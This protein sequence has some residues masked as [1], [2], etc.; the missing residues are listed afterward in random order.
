MTPL[1]TS[2]LHFIADHIKANGSSP[3]FQAIADALEIKSKA[4][5]SRLV[6]ILV[7][8]GMVSRIARHSCN[9][10]ITKAG[11]NHLALAETHGAAPMYWRPASDFKPGSLDG[12]E[13]FLSK[14]CE[15]LIVLEPTPDKKERQ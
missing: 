6:K 4:G 14:D 8:L 10:Q 1:Q 5:I 11:W 9:I 13:F 12:V 3:T 2:T 15:W 7:N